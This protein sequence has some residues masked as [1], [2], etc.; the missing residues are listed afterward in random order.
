MH[1]FGRSE[2]WSR[3]EGWGA[4]IGKGA[5]VLVVGRVSQCPDFL[6]SAI[7]GSERAVQEIGI[8]VSQEMCLLV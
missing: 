8:V 6:L 3:K 1:T 4:G 2:V 5:W 7:V